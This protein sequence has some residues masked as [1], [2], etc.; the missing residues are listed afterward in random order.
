MDTLGS[1]SKKSLQEAGF[2]FSK[3]FRLECGYSIF[4]PT[5]FFPVFATQ[6]ITL[7]QF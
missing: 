7:K 5:W 2:D 1:I 3:P 4:F 6:T